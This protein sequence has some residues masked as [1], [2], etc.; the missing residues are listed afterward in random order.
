MLLNRGARLKHDDKKRPF[1]PTKEVTV[2]T[3]II[4]MDFEQ[5]FCHV[6]LNIS[7][8]P[9]VIAVVLLSVYSTVLYQCTDR[10]SI[11]LQYSECSTNS[12]TLLSD[13]DL[14]LSNK[15]VDGTLANL[16][17][18]PQNKRNW[19]NDAFHLTAVCKSYII[20]LR[21]CFDASCILLFFIPHASPFTALYSLRPDVSVCRGY[22]FKCSTPSYH[23]F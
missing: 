4:R 23:L 1:L 9:V 19:S 18:I 6:Y 20:S 15:D 10:W 5:C 8:C 3:V 2:W 21:I 14:V 12:E 11:L 16:L 7:D 13:E 22:F 17:L